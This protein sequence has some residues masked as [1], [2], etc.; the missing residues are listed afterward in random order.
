MDHFQ[1][2]SNANQNITLDVSDMSSEALKLL[3]KA[4]N[5][6]KIDGAAD[7]LGVEIIDK[8]G[9]L[10]SLKFTDGDATG[11]KIVVTGSVKTG[12]LS[13]KVDEDV[14]MKDL[15]SALEKAGLKVE[16][17]EDKYNGGTAVG[18]VATNLGTTGTVSLEK[19]EEWDTI[20]HTEGKAVINI[21]L[22]ADGTLST[23]DIKA[24]IEATAGTGVFTV[25]ADQVDLSAS[26]ASLKTDYV[27][28][29]TKVLGTKKDKVSNLDVSTQEAADKAITTVNNALET[30]S[31]QSNQ[32]LSIIGTQKLLLICDRG[33]PSL[34]FFQHLEQR[35]IR[36]VMRLKSKDYKAERSA[37]ISFSVLYLVRWT[38]RQT[39]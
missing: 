39:F 2:G 24:A 17:D 29:E 34:E 4:G 18:T 3:E 7:A 19:L 10:E 1:I 27:A 13:F 12:D 23:A 16:I 32:V 31:Q 20:A 22:T 33:Y 38:Q 6:G 11:G 8:T 14:K 5:A 25:T 21:K 30:V 15:V 9:T 28:D 36:F 35:N 37:M 26:T